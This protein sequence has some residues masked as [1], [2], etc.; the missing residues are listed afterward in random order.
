MRIKASSGRDRHKDGDVAELAKAANVAD[1][2]QN[3]LLT[4]L[5]PDDLALLRPRLQH[6]ELKLREI[7]ESSGSQIRYVYF[8]IGAIASVVSRL[9]DRQ[10]EVGVV[11][12]DGMTGLAVVLDEDAPESETFVQASGSAWRIGTE[13][14]RAAMERSPTL[15][16]SF[17]RYIH[18]F[19]TQ[20][21]HTAV[22]NGHWRIEARLARRLLL[23]HDLV[24]GDK[25]SLTHDYL[26][27]ML[28][29]GRPG[30][31][32]ALHIL[33]GQGFIR[34]RRSEITIL[35][36]DGLMS[37]ARGSYGAENGK[38]PTGVS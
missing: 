21:E 22:V 14:L 27:T 7:L 25:I 37:L 9:A 15:R 32:V 2:G 35:N 26:A 8:P 3:Q 34:S 1:A 31:T 5:L 28:G 19:L 24:D 23:G 13:D 6:V 33:E 29:A 17:L 30:V 18:V 11:G 38:R 20:T 16:S 10:V 36:R 12:R 4:K